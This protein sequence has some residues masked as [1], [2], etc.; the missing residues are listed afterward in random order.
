MLP[1]EGANHGRSLPPLD[2]CLA[3]TATEEG[4]INGVPGCN[5]FMVV[6]ARRTYGVQGIA[7]A[8]GR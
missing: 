1:R 2:E 7:W 8:A 6:R 4:A 5:S 3:A